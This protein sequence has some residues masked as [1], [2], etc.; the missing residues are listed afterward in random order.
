VVT[1]QRSGQEE[2]C[3]KDGLVAPLLNMRSEI[4]IRNGVLFYKQFIR[5][6]MDYAC[7]LGVPPPAPTSEGCRYYN[8]SVF[9]SLPVLL[10]T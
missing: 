10:G 4:S 5:P 6:V 1:S 7:P 2:S 9:A 3:A 8:P